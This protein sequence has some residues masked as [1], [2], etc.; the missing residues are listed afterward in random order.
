LTL[1]T[2]GRRTLSL[3]VVLFL[4]S[5]F[6]E[7]TGPEL[8]PARLAILPSFANPHAARVVDFD[9]VRITLRRPGQSQIAFDTVISFPS[10][11]DSLR[12]ELAVPIAGTS[13]TFTY[14]LAM[15][16]TTL[17]D[18]VFV[19]GGAVTATSNALNLS[20]AQ[21]V[22][23]YVGVGFDA[24]GVRFVT[25]PAAAFFGATV[26]L[27]AEAFDSGGAVIPGT[28]IVFVLANP[29]DS[30]RARIPDEAVGQ[31]LVGQQRGNVV[32]RAE[33]LTNQFAPHT[34]TVQP[35][36][37]A[38][39]V[40]AGNNQTGAAGAS[41]GA[42]VA[43][44]LAA[45]GLG[46][47]GVEVT[48]AVTAGG[49]TLSAT[50]DTSDANGDASTVWTLGGTLGSQAMTATAAG[51]TGSTPF[52][53]TATPGAA[54]QL[55]FLVQPATVDEAAV[56][57][58]AI[59][60]RAL[61]QFGNGVTTF[62]GTVTIAIGINPGGGALGGTLSRAAAAG[63]VATFNDLT[64]SIAGTG[65]TLVATSGT[66]TA[67][68]S[69]AFNVTA[70]TPVA[71]QFQVPPS[72]VQAGAVITPAVQ[73]R[74]VT[75]SGAT[76][77][78][79]TNAVTIAIGTNPALGS[80][81]GTVMVNAIAGIA[82]FNDLRIDNI[83]TGYTLAA[84]ATGLAG[85][86][87]TGFDVLAPVNAVSWINP[88]G[89]AWSVGANW[90]TGTVPAAL[91]TVFI[92]QTG[93]Y[94]VVL[95]VNITVGRLDVGGPSG[96]QTLAV[97]GNILTIAGA[98]AVNANGRLAFSGGT[99]NGTGTLDV[100]G[101]LDWSGGN[102]SGGAGTTRVMPGGQLTIS[103][104]AA[105]TLNNYT[106]E[107][108]GAASVIADV[109]INSGSSG[110]LRNAAG[111]TFD[112][113]G[114]GQLLFNQGGATSRFD[115]LGTFTSNPGAGQ[116]TFTAPFDNSGTV[117]T[118][119][120]TTRLNAGGGS[121]G[122]FSA[123]AGSVLSFG[124]GTHTLAAAS[125]V[126]G[127][128]EV[129][130]NAGIVN[131]A[132][133]W[134]V[135]GST[136]V[137]GGTFNYDGAAGT[138]AALD[139]GGGATGGSGV[140]T[141]TGALTWTSGN[142]QGGSGTARVQSGA[143]LAII[144]TA[145][146]TLNNHTL[147][148][149]GTGVWSGTG[150]INSGSA[151]TLRVL[152][153]A[154]LDITGDPSLQFN[155]GG[156][157]SRF[158]VQGAV[159]RTTSAGG[160]FVSAEYDNDGQTTVSSGQLVLTGGSGPGAADGGY[161]VN[162]GATLNF[163]GGS[164]VLG[165]AGSVGGAGTVQISSGA[166]FLAG[167]YAITGNTQVSG[168]SF[169][170]N[171]AGASTTN[172][173]LLS[174]AV[175]GSGLLTVSGNLNWTAGSF[176]SGAGTTR[177]LA[178]STVTLGGT[179]A[180]VLNAYTLEIGGTGSWNG[181]HT[182]NSGSAGTLRVL[183]TGTLDI[184]ADPSL[185]F[186]QGGAASRLHNQGTINRTA[187]AGT[188]NLTAT[189]D[190]DGSVSVQTGVLRLAGGG[191][192]I[193]SFATSAGVVL[194][195]AAG[196]HDV[197]AASAV[198][199]TGTVRVSGGT[200]QFT[201]AYTLT[202]SGL[203]DV[204]GGTAAF[205]SAVTASTPTLTVQSGTLGGNG[206]FSVPGSF[207]WS[208]GSLTGGAGTTRVE[209][210]GSLSI[211]TG[212]ARTLGGG[213]TL[214]IAGT[215]TWVAG[216]INSG[217]AATLRVLAGGTLEVQ[218][219]SLLFNLGGT[220]SRLEVQA[221][222]TLTHN[223]SV[224]P[225][226]VT[227]EYDNDGQTVVSAGTLSLNG[228]SGAGTA[229]GVYQ[230]NAIGTLEFGG[231]THALG[232]AGTVSGTGT[233]QVSGGTVNAAGAWNVTSPT[234]VNGGTLNYNNA[235]GGTTGALDLSAG[236][237]GGTGLLT[238]SGAMTWT[239]GS[240]AGAGGTTRVLSGGT[241]SLAGGTKTLNSG[242]TLENAGTATWSA[243]QFNT[244]SGAVLRNLAGGT[245][246]IT[247]TAT[248][249]VLYNLGGAAPSFENA[250]T[251]NRTSG[252]GVPVIDVAFVNTGTVNVTVD[253]LR[254]QGGGSLGTTLALT[255]PGVLD[256]TAGTYTLTP[257]MAVTGNG[258][259][260]VAGATLNT[261]TAN[262]SVTINR[263]A[264]AS[265]TIGG[266]GIVRVANSFTW[267][268]GSLIGSATTRVLAGGFSTFSGGTKTLNGGH[269]FDTDAQV[270]WTAGDIN[271]GGGSTILNRTSRLFQISG[272]LAI[273]HNLGGAAPTFLNNGGI[274]KDVTTGTATIDVDLIS[275]GP[276][277]NTLDILAGT[278]E[279]TGNSTLGGAA[280]VGPG[281]ALR[282]SAGTHSFNNQFLV[283][284]GGQL[285]VAGA[286]L[287]GVAATDSMAVALGATL[288]FSSGT[289][290]QG[291]VRLQSGFTSNWTGG[292]MA[293]PGI[294]RVQVG[295]TLNLAGGTKTLNNGYLIDD[296]AAVTWSAGD[297]NSGNGAGIRVAPGATLNWTADATFAH[298]LG[299]AA[300][301]LVNEGSFTVNTGSPALAARIGGT[302]IDTVGSLLAITSGDLM[303]IG[304]GRLG[305]A[306]QIAA[307][308]FIEPSG[309]TL[310][311]Q[312][313]LSIAGAGNLR[314]N[315][316]TVTVDSGSSVGVPVLELFS[317]ALTHEGLFSVV[318]AMTWDG[319]TISSN[320]VGLGGTTR[321]ESGATLAIGGAA[322]KTLGGVHTL[323]LDGSATATY[324]GLGA[325]SLGAS[326]SILQV[327]SLFDW[328][329]DG[330]IGGVGTLRNLATGTVRRSTSANPAPLL[331]NSVD[332][333][334]T[335]DVT[336]GTLR[337]SSSLT[338]TLG[339]SNV[340]PGALLEFS[341]SSAW[342]ITTPFTVNGDLLISNGQVTPSGN[343]AT[344]TGNLTTTG[345]G[346]LRVVN[347]A[348]SVDIGG[349]V[350]FGGAFG[351]SQQTNGVIRV[352][353]N[354]TQL[355]TGTQYAPSGPHRMVLD[356]AG[357]QTLNFATTTTSFFRRLE[358]N[359]SGGGVVLASN[360]RAS[361]LRIISATA[362][363]G[364]TARLLTDSVFGP[365][366]ASNLAPL[367]L[368]VSDLLRDSGAVAPDTLVYTGGATVNQSIFNKADANCTLV[369][370]CQAYT[371]KSVRVNSANPTSLG[372]AGMTLTN[373]LVVSSGRLLMN[374]T[375]F[376]VA[377]SFRTEGT[378]S[379]QS[380]IAAESLSVGGDVAF[381]GG[382]TA[383]F[384]TGGGITLGG[385]FSQT[386]AADA[387]APTGAHRVVFAG[388]NPGF[389]DITFANPT[390]SFFRRLV[391][392]RQ[393]GSGQTVRLMSNVLVTDS[394]V[395]RNGTELVSNAA[396][397]I[398]VQGTYRYDPSAVN[399]P[400]VRPFVLELSVNPFL[401]SMTAPAAPLFRPDTL[402]LLGAGGFSLPFSN[403]TGLRSVRQTTTG[404]ISSSFSDPRDSLAGDLVITSGRF[405]LTGSGSTVVR[406]F[407]TLGTGSLEMNQ[408]GLTLI[409]RD[410]AI[411]A[412]ASSNPFLNAGTIRLE[413]H[414]FQAGDPAA[415]NGDPPHT[416]EFAGTSPQTVFF[417]NPGFT[418]AL[419]HFPTVRFANTTA[420]GVTFLSD[421]FTHV[422]EDVTPGTQEQVFG[423]GFLLTTQGANVDN[424]LYNNT[425]LSFLDSFTYTRFDNVTFQSYPT[426]P[427]ILTVALSANP[428][429]F[430]G[431]V[432][433]TVGF[434]GRYLVANEV[435]GGPLLTVTLAGATPGPGSGLCAT[436][437]GAT[438]SWNGGAC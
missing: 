216:T 126:G 34:L 420:G 103:T 114:G 320:T 426:N 417:T 261:A 265:G 410:S 86:T 357:T 300:P 337:I 336:T 177:G 115:N 302:F 153:G 379:L 324:T 327:A 128:G 179:G 381:G 361:R 255:V 106:L 78:T 250:G 61:D 7:S 184:S 101:G 108:R 245:F 171:G 212:V 58:P 19:A 147:E 23:N 202:G 238:V 205:S 374:G 273:N 150:A 401:D 222:A 334:G 405:Q 363:T 270:T 389:K 2:V 55:A 3:V 293:G 186:N 286:T 160:V 294:L 185:L 168:G 258:T 6:G 196:T 314:I 369:T 373:D 25:A 15:Y 5:C 14:A 40:Q 214:A 252:A 63:G 287:Q 221:G 28:P 279:L 99:L 288:E 356:G 9:R 236:T 174:G 139:L 141:T 290:G 13:E 243:G 390:T 347:A 235:A 352:A 18:T 190:N 175:G 340:A 199:G 125:S 323:D 391:L 295:H 331:V 368:E 403:Y 372:I 435:G 358:I 319:G 109:V 207:T 431:L 398:T 76:A 155:Q 157:A 263:L 229:D 43:R 197:G 309:G 4:M 227:A 326:G 45:D 95:D 380:S 62:T 111:G 80:L 412:G 189:F 274:R 247:L 203:T 47:Q 204:N 59:T 166:V 384:L 343:A 8:R 289:I 164:H 348:D 423:G 201:G 317:G 148:L 178:G 220:P 145:A 54:T 359:K 249:S 223:L 436:T 137:I 388:S 121:S 350:S 173:N 219:V 382:S 308:A 297:V 117:V 152:S 244:G 88:A 131:A 301:T 35:V 41:L 77:S 404:N 437:A 396:E 225:F 60:V 280:F 370:Q 353:G 176:S 385:S 44:V 38:I 90:S 399:D 194:E 21:P 333:Q 246:N 92:R 411:F 346:H 102:F 22:L 392:D 312:G 209:A 84:T 291:V 49:G 251:L 264:L 306:P 32:I 307:G 342:I 256:L 56:I 433:P 233:V 42:V 365:N 393:A 105:R 37:N 276:V 422:L 257:G 430:N 284:D 271:T 387:F 91:D 154:T 94:T 53:A 136:R 156:A 187:S 57:T 377:G 354:V 74:L 283:R 100:L 112:M 206:V 183:A 305:G 375:R 376:A 328:Q 30:I 332:N 425:R 12:L 116:T 169:F 83:G 296:E 97:G 253:S 170:Y 48:F 311:L 275:P 17:A 140:L 39:Q 72:G 33:L 329:G 127:A 50:R 93:T 322:T 36:P 416:V 16:N 162:A 413:G 52:S 434:S 424:V 75:S 159:N 438:I 70:T 144:G 27:V 110:T 367:V 181:S 269:T 383:G 138:T 123:G 268:G 79:A 208:G 371:L 122:S 259:V 395:T 172:L 20:V 65:Y 260:R 193:G 180:R 10:G 344:I 349:N 316:A 409:V 96:V 119:T 200:A 428:P 325:I 82:T 226:T 414:F 378:G 408:G 415:Y 69:A 366:V 104:T 11:A 195:F 81:S 394:L 355:G 211:T 304:G 218:G 400:M 345:I 234:Q 386:G 277:P 248:A 240:L 89:G 182:I 130:I 364:P 198:T 285:Q 64:V 427:D 167:G 66:L 217:S 281:R 292:T 351:G 421:V 262:D 1:R 210:G 335:F 67:A 402:V 299:G 330:A 132:G 341:S 418:S 406:K 46:V 213:Y 272:D 241:L 165:A 266:S 29:A 339:T 321:V 191:T 68:T 149:A 232:A 407:K 254:I 158:E 24:A 133:G 298:N 85:A 107:N 98:S 26:N 338:P 419:S 432:F 118:Q 129:N 215:G 278:L 113:L 71:L 231:G 161:T 87:S 313:G 397:R 315:G 237:L 135:T 192:S 360:V 230:A 267:T 124:G 31:V 362:V 242:Y 429:T 151:G 224:T 142:L 188:V 163:N 228:G 310:S 73:V 282:L 303:L 143:T 146:R 239:G 51:V 134:A 318:T 120:G